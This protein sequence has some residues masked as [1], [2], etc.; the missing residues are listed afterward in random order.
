[1]S[2]QGSTGR[3]AAFF[4]LEGA[5][6]GR[7]ATLAAAWMG[8]QAQRIEERAVR[9]G[10]ALLAAPFE[11]GLGDAVVGHRLAWSALRG[12]SEDRL[13]VLGEE[14]AETWLIPH[15]RPVGVDLLEQCR[16]DGCDLVL[17]SDHLAPMADTV[18]HHLRVGHVIANRL[19][20]RNGRA[21]GRLEDPVVGRLGAGRLRELAEEHGWDLARSR[22][23]GASGDDQLL[24][25]AIGLPCAVHPDRALRR[26][27]VDLD[28]PVVEG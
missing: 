4:R 28:W 25:A 22:A 23:Y 9:I 5:L 1:M 8:S 7:P 10:A 21:T 6:V 17:I 14:Y 27:A 2:D 16:R 24:L 15:L 18:G 11:L 13:R 19:E 20:L 3:P 26:V 12:T